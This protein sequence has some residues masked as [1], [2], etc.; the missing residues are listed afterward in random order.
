M[1]LLVSV[2]LIFISII[3]SVINFKKIN[4]AL[5]NHHF[6]NGKVNETKKEGCKLKGNPYMKWSDIMAG[7]AIDK[8]IDAQL[9]YQ[10]LVKSGLYSDKEYEEL[11]DFVS[12]CSRKYDER[13]RWLCDH[14]GVEHRGRSTASRMFYDSPFDYIITTYGWKN[15]VRTQWI[16][17]YKNKADLIATYEKHYNSYEE[18]KNDFT[19]PFHIL[20]TNAEYLGRVVNG[21]AVLGKDK[22]IFSGG[23][24]VNCP[25]FNPF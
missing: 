5:I 10:R 7:I 15:G 4:K 25:D 1:I 20:D 9:D 14:N 2:I 17:G 16:R 13:L 19:D 8:W 21:E 18:M 23:Y 3:V 11:C 6:Y 24:T 12:G 22:G